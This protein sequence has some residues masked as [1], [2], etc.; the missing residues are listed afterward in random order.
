MKG[1]SEEKGEE[2]TM[3][4]ASR[5]SKSLRTPVLQICGVVEFASL[6]GVRRA[7]PLVILDAKV[8][9]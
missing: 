9:L 6:Y 7:T 2:R 1:D 3:N 5:S 4:T 8:G